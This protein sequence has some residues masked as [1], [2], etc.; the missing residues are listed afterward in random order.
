MATTSQKD[1]LE[2]EVMRVNAAGTAAGD[3]GKNLLLGAMAVVTDSKYEVRQ[4]P[5]KGGLASTGQDP[6][7]RFMKNLTSH[8]HPTVLY[9]FLSPIPT[10]THV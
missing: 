5:S 1:T 4:L 7:Y 9:L 10:H 6:A 2:R 8:H 3:T